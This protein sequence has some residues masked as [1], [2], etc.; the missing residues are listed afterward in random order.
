[1]VET[2]Y[3]V[4]EDHCRG[5]DGGRDWTAQEWFE[6]EGL[7]PYNASNDRYMRL[8]AMVTASGR[9]LEEK[10]ANLCVVC[11]YQLDNFRQLIGKMKIFDRVNLPEERR[12]AV[13]E[14]DEAALDFAFDWI[15]LVL[16][17]VSEN[18]S[19]KKGQ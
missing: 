9:P 8:A 12:K 1:V 13:M 3:L 6:H 7:L 5:F 18:L 4:Q 11:C 10:L 2:H 17:G 15:E 19:P 14:S 16:F